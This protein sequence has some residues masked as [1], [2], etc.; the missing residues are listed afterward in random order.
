MLYKLKHAIQKELLLLYRDWGG[1]LILFIMPL[2]LVITVTLIQD[3]SFKSIH[4]KIKIAI[5]N[6]DNDYVSEN[7]INELQTDSSFS[8]ITDINEQPF[9]EESIQNLVFD[10]IFQIGIIIPEHLSSELNQ[11][12][13]NNLEQL[14]GSFTNYNSED[15][16]PKT[17]ITPQKIK[18]YFDPAI[19]PSYKKNIQN[20]INQLVSKEENNAIYKAFQEQFEEEGGELFDQNQFIYFEEITP[21]NI[22]S[23]E[24]IPNAVQHNVP[25]WTL[26]AMFFIVVPLSINIIKEK[27]QGTYVR[28]LTSP[29]PYWIL[30]TG[31]IITYLFINILQFAL[32]LCIGKYLFPIFGLIALEIHSVVTLLIIALCCGLAAIGF[33]IA[34]GTVAKTQE[35]SA[36]FGATSVIIMAAL[37]GIWVPVFAMPD[38]MHYIA[39]ISPMNWGLEAFYNILLRN[40]P[41]TD[42][43]IYL[44]LLIAFFISMLLFSIIY[45]KKN[46]TL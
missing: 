10:G 30:L 18:L 12:V 23:K 26:F 13:N 42:T 45:D 37:G 34:I 41:L 20:A 17:E 39:K 32:M 19:H 24:F 1:L 43:L 33:G 8:I 40:Q 28:L 4:T 21:Q 15:T 3:S 7:I 6:N 9:T 22:D 46:R 31:K 5:L 29:T 25:A 38:F 27:N 11:K 44:I 16:S 14:I 35:Q 2:V 36:P